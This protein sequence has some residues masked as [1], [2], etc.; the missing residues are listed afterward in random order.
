[1]KYKYYA[2]IGSRETPPNVLKMMSRIA[3]KLSNHGFI[4]RS[5]GAEG[6]D[7]AFFEGSDNRCEVFIPWDKFNNFSADDKTICNLTEAHFRL[8]ESLHPAWKKCSQGA[9]KLH[10]RNTQQILGKDLDDPVDFVIC[11]TPNGEVVGGTATAI[12]LAEANNIRIFNLAKPDDYMKL[13][14]MLR[15]TLM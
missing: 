6:A 14:N 15:A 13:K 4:L 3:F 1:M 12:R 7:K 8:A 11:W 2:G 5:G 10:A 9:Q